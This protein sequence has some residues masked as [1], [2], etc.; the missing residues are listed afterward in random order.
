MIPTPGNWHLA[1]Q[2]GHT[3]W[4]LWTAQEESLYN[5]GGYTPQTA[6]SP[7]IRSTPYPFD[8]EYCSNIVSNARGLNLSERPYALYTDPEMSFNHTITRT[9]GRQYRAGLTHAEYIRTEAPTY[10]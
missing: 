2:V 6:L 5:H 9:S 1:P 7:G 3:S 4:P 8:N 10:G